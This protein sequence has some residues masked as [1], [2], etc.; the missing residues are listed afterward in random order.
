MRA[1]SL[2]TGTFQSRVGAGCPARPARQCVAVTGRY[3][4]RARA[5]HAGA[6]ELLGLDSREEALLEQLARGRVAR[7]PERAR[8]RAVRA[9]E[10]GRDMGLG[11]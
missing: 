10:H 7:E 9:R 8:E 11:R 3:R 6:I 1:L 4:L 2:R 5:E